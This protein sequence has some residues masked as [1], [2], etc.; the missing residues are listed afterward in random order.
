MCLLLC[1]RIIS[2]KSALAIFD[3][4]ITGERKSLYC[5]RVRVTTDSPWLL[6]SADNGIGICRYDGH[7]PLEPPEEDDDFVAY[8]TALQMVHQYPFVAASLLFRELF[9]EAT[10]FESFS[11]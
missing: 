7:V 8:L 4:Y 11:K 10:A 6:A 3:R 2:R 5:K 9:A 1:H